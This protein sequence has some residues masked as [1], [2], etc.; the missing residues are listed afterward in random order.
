[1]HNLIIMA[2]LLLPLDGFGAS[3]LK[4]SVN[5]KTQA[6]SVEMMKSKVGAKTYAVESPFQTGVI[7]KYEGVLLTEMLRRDPPPHWLC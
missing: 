7:R 1:M 5:G 6:F 2:F 3:A 4:I